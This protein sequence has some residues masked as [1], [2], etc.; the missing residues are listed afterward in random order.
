ME[1]IV[2]VRKLTDRWILPLRDDSVVDIGWGPEHVHLIL[3]SQA[4]IVV[5][6]GA[7]VVAMSTPER[8]VR[9]THV[10]DRQNDE[11]DMPG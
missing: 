1:E 5:G 3:D 2:V 4:S 10:R 7:P 8:W 11:K 6:Y 9:P